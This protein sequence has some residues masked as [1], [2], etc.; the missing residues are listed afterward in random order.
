ME[1]GRDVGTDLVHFA[2]AGAIV[3]GV[4]ISDF[5]IQ[6]SRKNLEIHNLNAEVFQNNGETLNYK[7]DSFDFIIKS[8]SV[9]DTYICNMRSHE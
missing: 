3:T 2:K 1:I 8:F 9:L 5:A 4:D 7:D 6:M